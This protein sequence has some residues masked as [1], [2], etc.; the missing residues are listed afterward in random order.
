[1][2]S[3]WRQ[4][5]LLTASSA[6]L[7]SSTPQDAPERPTADLDQDAFV[8]RDGDPDLQ[9]SFSR[10]GF[11]LWRLNRADDTLHVAERPSNPAEEALAEIRD[12]LLVSNLG[13]RL[14]VD[15][16]QTDTA[17]G[18]DAAH[19]V[20]TTQTLAVYLY[21]VDTV[22]IPDA[23]PRGRGLLHAA[24][25]LRHAWQ[26]THGLWDYG[27]SLSHQDEIARMFLTEADAR[28]FAVAV[29]WELREAGD[30]EAW[31]AAKSLDQYQETVARF[32]QKMTE[33]ERLGIANGPWSD[34]AMRHAMHDA[35]EAWFDRPGNMTI[36]KR[37]VD[38]M[39]DDPDQPWPGDAA[40]P[41]DAVEIL[42]RLPSGSGDPAR[43]SASY[44][45]HHDLQLA[46][47]HAAAMLA[48]KH[49][50]QAESANETS[51]DGMATLQRQSPAIAKALP[52]DPQEPPFTP[53]K[54]RQVAIIPRVYSSRFAPG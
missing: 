1:M 4:L 15:L 50:A 13:R 6:F 28:A 23:T 42:G 17:L 29:A 43:P 52:A 30:P 44:L 35:Y 32:E 2:S 36:Y 12:S 14:L 18:G 54:E 48:P 9:T 38:N 31:E 37:R 27:K 39:L 51:V 26:D 46:R 25:E 45:D 47:E 22:V 10:S 3:T 49:V 16:A 34:W 11:N 21:N 20:D 5:L 41:A 40:L 53:P 7:T 33:I 24:H 19:E 8:L